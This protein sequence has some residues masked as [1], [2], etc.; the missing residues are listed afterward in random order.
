MR[1]AGLVDA[2]QGL[3]GG[4]QLPTRAHPGVGLRLREPFHDLVP[5]DRAAAADDVGVALADYQRAAAVLHR[6][7]AERRT[8]LPAETRRVVD[9]NLAVIDAAITELSRAVAAAP[10]DRNL[11]RLLVATYGRQIELLE[12]ANRL[13]RT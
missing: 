13:S 4:S 11:T 1:L 12:T 7:L 9:Q 6:A 8:A 5:R 10:G 2:G 3:V